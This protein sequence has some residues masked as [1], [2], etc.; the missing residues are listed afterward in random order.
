MGFWVQ[1]SLKNRSKFKGEDVKFGYKTKDLNPRARL[2][3]F[4]EIL[5]PWLNPTTLRLHDNLASPISW[6]PSI[7]M[8]GTPAE[9]FSNHEPLLPGSPANEPSEKLA[10]VAWRFWLGALCKR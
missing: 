7:V 10:R 9:N 6:D 2:G 1:G 3:L 5:A 8:T 4:A